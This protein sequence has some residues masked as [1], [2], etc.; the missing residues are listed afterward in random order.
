MSVLIPVYCVLDNNCTFIFSQIT[1]HNNHQ[2]TR[3]SFEICVTEDLKI[4]SSFDYLNTLT[5]I[6]L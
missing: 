4:N 6:Q 3:E 5:V 1:Q 2:P